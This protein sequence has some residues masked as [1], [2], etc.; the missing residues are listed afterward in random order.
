VVIIIIIIIIIII[1]PL[2]GSLVYLCTT[3]FKGCGL[4]FCL[5]AKR[6]LEVH[7][8]CYHGKTVTRL[9]SR[10]LLMQVRFTCC[11]SAVVNGISVSAF[12]ILVSVVSTYFAIRLPVR[13][14]PLMEILE[15]LFFNEAHPYVRMLVPS[16]EIQ[17]FIQYC[18][19]QYHQRKE[20]T[21]WSRSVIDHSINEPQAIRTYGRFSW[22]GTPFS[23]S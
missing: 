18:F 8:E 10:N 20:N 15:F 19:I 6:I 7:L 16:H 5:L 11:F 22:F 9:L 2:R 12:V 1:K 23:G 17:H 4:E 3:P 21:S 13:R 14:N